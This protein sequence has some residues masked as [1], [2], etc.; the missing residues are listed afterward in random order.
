MGLNLSDPAFV[1]VVGSG[2]GA[3]VCQDISDQDTTMQQWNGSSGNKLGAGCL[4]TNT[5]KGAEF[6]GLEVDTVGVW[7]KKSAG[8]PDNSFSVGIFREASKTTELFT[9]HSGD[10]ST[11][12]TSMV[13]YE[14]TAPSGT[15]TIA[16]GDFVGIKYPHN[17]SSLYSRIEYGKVY[18]GLI[19]GLLGGWDAPPHDY[20]TFD[21]N[22]SGLTF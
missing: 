11:V 3:E 15:H 7:L 17:G 6:M 20:W 4:M 18:G 2:G 10:L 13:Y 8:A 1:G 16:T 21:S 12:T 9:F 14:F 5:G 22:S 19:F